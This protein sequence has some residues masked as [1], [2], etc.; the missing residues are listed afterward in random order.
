MREMCEFFSLPFV[1]EHELPAS[2]DINFF[3]SRCDYTATLS[4]YQD[5]YARFV[6]TLRALGLDGNIDAA[7]SIID[8]WEPAPDVQV[9]GEERIPRYSPEE[10]FNLEQ[11][12]AI[13][14]G[15]PDEAFVRL[16][17]I[18]DISQSW[19]RSRLNTQAG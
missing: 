7:G 8:C 5:T 12:L 6:Q 19:Y 9:A 4:Q 16:A 13:C 17:Q 18:R 1:A 10:M 2:M 3:L 15:I 11:Q 14:A